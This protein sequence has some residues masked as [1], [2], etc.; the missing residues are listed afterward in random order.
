MN[1]FAKLKPVQKKTFDHIIAGGGMAGL[2]LAFYLNESSLKDKKVL[3]IDRDA[4]N[5]NDHTWC[6]WEKGNSAFEEIVFRRWNKFWFHGT[7]NFNELL[8]LNDY[9]YKMIRAIDFYNF[10]IPKLE[11]NP[12]F[13]F[14]Q[15]DILEVENNSVKTNRG[16]FTA[17]D[18]I[19]DSFT[20]KKYDNPKY[21]NLWQHFLG[22]E[23]ETDENIF[24]TDEPTLFDFRVV[25]KNECRFVYILPV[26]SK[27]ALIEFT[28]FS[29][30]LIEK[31]EYEANLQKYI[32]EILKVENYRINETEHGI[33]PMSDEP[34]EEFPGAKIIRIGTSGGYVK[35]ST[36][37][38]FKRT[39]KH[40]Q[41]L[42]KSLEKVQ[43]SN[44]K[45]QSPLKQNW[46]NYLDGVLLN[47]LETKKHSAAD[48]FTN[49][50]MRNET[51]QVLKFLD[52][53]TSV[54]EDL[55]IMKTVPLVPF[56]KA[57]IQEIFKKLK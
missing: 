41:G 13:T 1:D 29:D 30:N 12:N 2:S 22:W 45:F 37:Y 10:I 54:K 24:K 57:A 26:S 6:F 7:N 20:R 15:A 56:T 21:H 18:F 43:I 53:E 50:F 32:S 8:E 46:K 51:S 38:S 5:T 33:I 11:A 36:G 16:E 3:I 9:Q 23:I 39:Q 4:K 19:F 34:H 55:Q 49:L 28:I 31:E 42:V 27:K 14:L 40:L 35:P 25:Q 47:V 17:K 44:F 48:I 52:E